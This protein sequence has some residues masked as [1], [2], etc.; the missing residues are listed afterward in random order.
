MFRLGDFYEMFDE[1]AKL[2]SQELELTLT[3]RDRG[4]PKEEQ[5]PMCGVPYHSC[6]RLHRPAGAEGLQGRHLRADGR[7]GHRQGSG[8][9]G[10]H[11]HH[12]PRHRHRK[13]HAG[14]EQ[15]QLHRL[16]LRRKRKIAALAFCDVSTG[17]FYAT[18]VL[19]ATPRDAA[20][21]SLAASPPAKCSA[22]VPMWTAR[23]LM[24]AVF[25]AG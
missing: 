4:K 22:T 14:R 13:L 19:A 7:P 16:H 18:T 11:P 1:D 15:K 5:T 24:D 17:A 2:T 8:A 21:T 10:H 23:S 6:G 20:S 3:T 12:H 9:A 25:T